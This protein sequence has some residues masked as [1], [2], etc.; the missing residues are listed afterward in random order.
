MVWLAGWRTGPAVTITAEVIAP[1]RSSAGNRRAL[2][3]RLIKMRRL[4]RQVVNHPMHEGTAGSIGI[5][6][7]QGETLGALRHSAPR[8]R[9]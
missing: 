8:Q 3:H 9:R 1:L 5:I 7:D 6:D 2:G 4:R